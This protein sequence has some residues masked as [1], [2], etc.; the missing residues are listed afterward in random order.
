MVLSLQKEPSQPTELSQIQPI[1]LTCHV[2]CH[3]KMRLI[4]ILAISNLFCFACIA[5]NGKSRFSLFFAGGRSH[6]QT[7]VE[8]SKTRYTTPEARAGVS[9]AYPLARKINLEFRPAFGMKLK[10]NRQGQ[11]SVDSFLNETTSLNYE[12]VEAPVLFDYS[13][14]R[15]IAAKLGINTRYFWPGNRIPFG[16][17]LEGQLD[18]GLLGGVYVNLTSRL[19]LGI[20]Y[21]AGLTKV[22]EMGY[23]NSQLNP[24]SGVMVIRN[25]FAQITSAWSLKKSPR[26]STSTH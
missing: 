24:Q 4:I 26:K 5:Q 6:F 22:N 20:E 2:R 14:N 9:I 13:V 17:V 15:L 16:T 12:F 21:T 1:L 25:H 11:F 18:I 23:F 10:G 3:L 7:N 8:P 19:S